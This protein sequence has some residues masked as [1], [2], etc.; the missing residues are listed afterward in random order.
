MNLTDWLLEGDA[1]VVYQVHR[2]LLRTDEKELLSL[3]QRIANEGWCQ[4]L[5]SLY[6]K[7]TSMWGGGVYGPKWIST[8]Y[9]MLDL[10]NF[11]VDPNHE[12]YKRSMDFLID[13]LWVLRDPKKPYM[14]GGC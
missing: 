10:K 12:V 13:Q 7:Q 5:L 6:D 2:D 11:A 4:R 8:T 9:T 1:S 3:Q 14:L